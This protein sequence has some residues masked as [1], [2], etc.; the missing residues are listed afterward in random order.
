MKISIVIPSYNEEGNILE[1]T[2]RLKLELEK[3]SSYEIIFID[4]GSLD[5]S[6]KLFEKLHDEDNRVNFISLSRNFGHQNALKAGLDFATGDCIISMDADLQHP[7]E[8]IL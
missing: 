7:T 2:N 5:G 1:I 8:L 6:L 3:Y 4:D